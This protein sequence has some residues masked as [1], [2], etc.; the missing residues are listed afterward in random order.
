[1]MPT[2]RLRVVLA[3]DLGDNFDIGGGTPGKV[4]IRSATALA[5]G[6]ERRATLTDLALRLP[7][8]FVDAQ[9]FVDYIDVKLQAFPGD[10]YV[11][12][13]ISYNVAT[14]K[15]VFD[16]GGGATSEIDATAL[17]QDAVN[18]AVA[19][20]TVVLTDAFGVRIGAVMP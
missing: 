8:P 18:E 2:Q 20:A 4:Q 12:G 15:M 11:Q 1:M 10:R 13:L 19:R 9:L 6:V 14:N 16:L 7:G 3:D 17:V 5:K